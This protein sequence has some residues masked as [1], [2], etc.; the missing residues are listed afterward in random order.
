MRNRIK[1][2]RK[3]LRAALERLGTPG[4]WSF[5]TKQNG[6]TT[7]IGLNSKLLPMNILTKLYMFDCD[8]KICKLI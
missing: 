5:I 6:I 2:A 8:V 1:E 3:D 4:D 7:L